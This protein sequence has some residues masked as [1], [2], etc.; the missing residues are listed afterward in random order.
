MIK[1]LINQYLVSKTERFLLS[2]KLMKDWVT[3][4]SDHAHFSEYAG[5][6]YIFI[7]L[8]VA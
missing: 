8:W 3:K 7:N 6:I 4:I 1:K 5:I 2:K